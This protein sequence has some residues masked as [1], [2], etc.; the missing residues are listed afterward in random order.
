MTVNDISLKIIPILKKNHVSKAAIFGSYARGDYNKKS[1]VD[2]LVEFSKRKSLFDLNELQYLL[3]DVLG[4]KVDLLTYSS[5]NHR[6]R[7]YIL[8][9]EKIIYEERT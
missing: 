8:R 7:D 3:E 6:L 2:I 5:I 1:D 4:K 9:D